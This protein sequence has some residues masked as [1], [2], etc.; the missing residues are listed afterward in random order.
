VDDLD[1]TKLLDILESND[2]LT[3]VENIKIKKHSTAAE[4]SKNK[5]YRLKNKSKLDKIAKIKAKKQASCGEGM[6]W[7]TRENKCIKK[8]QTSGLKKIKT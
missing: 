3:E 8:K 4:K 2:L 1:I 6:T 5:Q 7:S